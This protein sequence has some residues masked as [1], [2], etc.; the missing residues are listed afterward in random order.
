MKQL[1]LPIVLFATV[2]VANAQDAKKANVAYAITD[3]VKGGGGWGMLRQ[4]NLTNGQASEILLNGFDVSRPAFDA[5]NGRQIVSYSNDAVYGSE[6][7][8]GAFATGVAAIAMDSRHNRLYYTPMRIDELRYVDLSNMQVN[9][10]QAVKFNVAGNFPNSEANV[11]TRMCFASDGFGY[12]LTND[13]NHLVRFTTDK[14]PVVT[15]LGEVL[16]AEANKGISIHN[17]CSSW[18]GDMIAD[19]NGNLY[20]FSMRNHVFQINLNTRVAKHL[21]QIKGLSNG[22][23]VNG[24]AVDNDGNVVVSSANTTVDYYKVNMNDLQAT[25]VAKEGKDVWNA[26]DLANGNLLYDNQVTKV[27]VQPEVMTNDAV[28][29]FPNPVTERVVNIQ[30]NA[31]EAGTY[32]LEI[33]DGNGRKIVQ[34]QVA[35]SGKG[36]VEKLAMNGAAGMYY[37]RILSGKQSVFSEKIVLQ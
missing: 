27:Q 25:V 26:S 24:V 32:T 13:A 9:I 29:V 36:Q 28:S 14:K 6:F 16:D 7:K 35:V 33:M 4:V 31:L 23:T 3:A 15:Q 21:G 10:V 12:A 34:K 19:A 18:G 2:A 20:V 1:F 5:V 37:L 11:F 17:Q 30:F 8:K 22:F